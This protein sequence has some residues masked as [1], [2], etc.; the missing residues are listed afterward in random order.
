MSDEK[1]GCFGCVH[2]GCMFATEPGSD[3][4]TIFCK[5][6]EVETQE[7]DSGCKYYEGHSVSSLLQKGE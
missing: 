2:A 5:T 7:V 6:Q 1:N 3:K 4:M